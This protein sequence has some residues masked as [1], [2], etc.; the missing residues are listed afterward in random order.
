MDDA[1]DGPPEH[2]TPYYQHE[3]ITVYIHTSKK[4]PRTWNLLRKSAQGNHLY[5]FNMS[6][7]TAGRFNHKPNRCTKSKL[8]FR[9]VESHTLF[10]C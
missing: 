8:I 7:A 1:S 10:T 2:G 6:E 9:K 5:H 4:M 3:R